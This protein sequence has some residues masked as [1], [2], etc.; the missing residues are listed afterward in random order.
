MQIE[1]EIKCCGTILFI[2]SIFGFLLTAVGFIGGFVFAVGGKIMTGQNSNTGDALQDEV[3]NCS[4]AFFGTLGLVFGILAIVVS[5]IIGIFSILYFIHSRRLLHEENLPMRSLKI[6]RILEI[7]GIILSTV[8]GVVTSVFM[9]IKETYLVFIPSVILFVEC[10][11]IT[12][13]LTK[14]A[15]MQK[16]R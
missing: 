14:I 4:T 1:K 6:L 15:K 11:Y 16:E 10:I 3:A 9:D 8:I 5:I 12:I 7:L 13:K 2:K